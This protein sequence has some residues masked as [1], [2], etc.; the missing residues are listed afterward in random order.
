MM[1]YEQWL[2]CK[3]FG[4]LLWFTNTNTIDEDVLFDGVLNHLILL[5]FI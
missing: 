2:R 3:T 5:Y 4:R 1:K